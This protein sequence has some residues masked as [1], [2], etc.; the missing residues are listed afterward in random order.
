MKKFEDVR[1]IQLLIVIDRISGIDLFSKQMSEIPIDPTLISGFLQAISSFGKDIKI[2]TETKKKALQELAFHHFLFV[3]EEGENVRSALLLLKSPSQEIKNSL[4]R[5]TQDVESKFSDFIK[6]QSGETL[7]N[8]ILNNMVEENYKISLSYVHE[9]KIQDIDEKSLSKWEKIIIKH[10][11]ESQNGYYLDRFI[12][13]FVYVYYNGK[14]LDFLKAI[15]NL[16]KKRILIPI[17]PELNKK[18][19]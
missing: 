14:E 6:E 8:E 18:L 12:E 15:L 4:S 16:K 9:L 19:K 17:I 7:D 11:Q 13:E 1:N 3:F 10:F 5:F 2:S